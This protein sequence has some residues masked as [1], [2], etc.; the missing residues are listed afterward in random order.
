[1]NKLPDLKVRCSLIP[2]PEYLSEDWYSEQDL[3]EAIKGISTENTK[4]QIGDAIHKAIEDPERIQ[5]GPFYV[6]DSALDL[7]KRLHA[8]YAETGG[9]ERRAET[10]LGEHLGY[11][12]FLPG[13]ADVLALGDHGMYGIDWKIVDASVG[14]DKYLRYHKSAQ[15]FAYMEAFDVDEWRFVFLQANVLENEITALKY[16]GFTPQY[17]SLQTKAK[18]LESCAKIVDFANFHG[19]TE[20]LHRNK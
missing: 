5:N 19:L 6:R 1:M 20:H 17:R 14:E 15:G 16:V 3:I 4:M 11:K 18:V 10:Y 9:F 8:R 13:H 7:C 2:Q 12:I